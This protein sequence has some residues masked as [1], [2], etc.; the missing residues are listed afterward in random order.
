[1]RKN[2]DSMSIQS[3]IGKGFILLVFLTTQTAG[4]VQAQTTADPNASNASA[5]GG[6]VLG[7]IGGVA[8]NF[9]S[10]LPGMYQQNPQQLM[11]AQ[12]QAM[13]QSK[14][15]ECQMKADPTGLSSTSST[16]AQVAGS[17]AQ[18]VKVYAEMRAKLGKKDK[19]AA[20]TKIDTTCNMDATDSSICTMKCQD[21]TDS[22]TVSCGKF[23]QKTRSET[24][25]GGVAEWREKLSPSTVA[26]KFEKAERFYRNK[27]EVC[28]PTG[29]SDFKK[30]ADAL[31]CMMDAMKMASGAAAQAVQATLAANQAKYAQMNQYQGEVAEQMAQVE[32]ILGPD[33]K[34]GEAGGEFKGLLGLQAELTAELQKAKEGEGNFEEAVAKV[35]QDQLA[36]DQ[37]LESERMQVVASCLKGDSTAA[38]GGKALMCPKPMTRKNNE[39]K[40]EYVTGPNGQPKYVNAACGPL[41]YIRAR[42]RQ[43]SMMDN[44][45]YMDRDSARVQESENNVAAYE[46]T[47]DAIMREMGSYEQPTAEGRIQSGVHTWADIEKNGQIMSKLRE[48]DSDPNLRG[49]NIVDNLKRATQK[50]MSDSTRWRAQQMAS[51]ASRY[52]KQ[53]LQID[54]T[55][56]KLNASLDNGLAE[57]NKHYKNVMSLLSDQTVALDRYSCKKDSAKMLECYR[58]I[59]QNLNDLLDGNGRTGFT[60]KMIKGGTM[61]GGFQVPCRGINGCVTALKTV[62]DRQKDHLALAQK[63]KMKF[64]NDGNQQVQQQLQG[65][66][67]VL[68][69]GSNA[70]TEMFSKFK[71]S[72]IAMGVT[73][74]PDGLTMLDPENLEQSMNGNGEQKEPGPFQNPKNMAAVLSGMSGGIVDPKDSGLGKAIASGMASIKEKKEAWGKKA[75][76]FAAAAAAYNDAQSTCAADGNVIGLN[77]K[78]AAKR[79]GSSQ[80]CN[81]SVRTLYNNIKESDPTSEIATGGLAAVYRALSGV[82]GSGFDYAE[83]AAKVGS[84]FKSVQDQDEFFT[85]AMNCSEFGKKPATVSETLGTA[86]TEKGK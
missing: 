39:G 43:Q 38:T 54:S 66:A 75:D 86:P 40:E 26:D 58:D 35:E 71:T 11:L 3:Q 63:A 46:G 73:D 53:K 12:Q 55:R 51:G 20:T 2:R 28:G 29:A 52:S 49:V 57:L 41:D 30:T 14:L 50:C 64:V 4:V 34:F 27:M 59:R 42:I 10:T 83:S 76:E 80:D 60:S 7:A 85:L 31:S 9:A 15:A 8:A 56:K 77:D 70:I 61:V 79:I 74:I 13:L 69:V 78:V 68:S 19:K 48:L 82:K 23:Y 5:G 65:F 32:N 25:G 81:A 44:G 17:A 84:Q 22:K 67:Q 72:M 37:T 21:P 33:P 62:R 24:D 1:M 47:I 6:G 18:A 36:N 45:R 16:G